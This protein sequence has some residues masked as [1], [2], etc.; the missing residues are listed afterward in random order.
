MKL[1]MYWFFGCCESLHSVEDFDPLQ[2]GEGLNNNNDPDDWSK[3]MRWRS[4]E[5]PCPECKAPEPLIFERIMRIT[6]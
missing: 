3:E 1:G 5:K 4:F 6:G 2:Q